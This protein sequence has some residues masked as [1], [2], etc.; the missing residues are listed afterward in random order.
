MWQMTTRCASGHYCPSGTSYATQSA[1]SAGTYT[2]S[3]NLTRESECS[4][5]P[6]TKACASGS[7]SSTWSECSPGH[8]CPEGTSTSTDFDCP[9]GTYSNR[10]NLASASQCTSAPPGYWAA[11][12][13]SYISGGCDVGY[14][15][16]LGSL[17]AQEYACPEGT[18]SNETTMHA[19]YQCQDC[20]PGY[21]CGEAATAMVPVPAGTYAPYN[22]T[23]L[24][25]YL[26]CSAGHFCVEGSSAM[27]ECGPGMHSKP[28]ASFCSRCE[29]GHYCGSNTTTTANMY[30]NGG[31]WAAAD[32]DEGRCF[33]G[34]YCPEGMARAPDLLRDACP[35]GHYCPVGTPYPLAC[36]AGTYQPNTGQDELADCLQTPAGSYS[37]EGSSNVTGLCAPGF[38]CGAG[39]SGPYQIPC[40]DRYYR[41]NYGG[42]SIESCSL[43]TA[44]GFCTSGAT[45][46]TVCPRGSYC[47]TGISEPEPCPLGTFGN[48]T[49]LR[50][51]EDC[52]PCTAGMYCDGLGLTVPRDLCD[53]GFYCTEASY[54]SAPNAPGTPLVDDWSSIGGVCPHGHYCST[55]SSYPQA[56]PSGTYNNITG[57]SSISDCENCPAGTFCAGSANTEPTGF[58]KEGYYT[59]EGSSSS[60]QY[61]APPGYFTKTG[62]SDPSPCL[63]GTYNPSS[64]QTSCLVCPAGFYC[65]NY[66]TITPVACP[67][68]KYCTEGTDVPE[69]CPASTYSSQL[70]L[71]NVTSCTV[72]PGGEYCDVNG[73]TAPAGLIKKGYYSSGTARS[74]T[75]VGEQYGGVCPLGSF[76]PEGSTGGTPCRNGTYGSTTGLTAGSECTLCPAGKYNAEAGSTDSSSCLMCPEG[77]VC[78]SGCS[79]P[80]VGVRGYYY[81][82]GTSFVTQYPCPN[83]TFSNRTQIVAESECF[84]CRPGMYCGEPGITSPTATCDAG[85]YCGGGAAAAR[86]DSMSLGNVYIG[87]TCVDR[88][89]GDINDVCPPGRHPI[90]WPA[91][92][93]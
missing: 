73:L 50:R 41:T 43:C 79:E 83:G 53:P 60:T 15:C 85:Y 55:G 28:A 20:A 35:T 51:V 68:G 39:S 66:S 93:S 76:C 33:N 22:N 63:P 24:D 87:D 26:N 12:G 7:T 65:F 77:F 54:T 18:W 75:P 25:E 84:P 38:W 3:L 37:I 86:P 90:K 5:C 32:D 11:G 42:E 8:F 36:P 21:F 29:A 13:L 4:A 82:A 1:C 81:P 61:E 57:S 44:G 78:E 89:T 80:A 70:Y 34:T 46:P 23:G 49:G 62:A 47:V 59:H 58:S 71:T 27:A 17:S 9:A 40:G 88:T 64:V 45:A 6:A 67:A 10:T 2:D 69:R 72:C 56:C 74:R 31:S 91:I 52:T 48:S 92:L 14:Y 30:L 16:P 19:L